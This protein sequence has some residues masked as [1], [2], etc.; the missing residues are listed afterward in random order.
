M[1]E[2]VPEVFNVRDMRNMDH[3]PFPVHVEHVKCLFT[4]DRQEFMQDGQEEFHDL[5]PKASLV[6][7]LLG[8]V[9]VETLVKYLKQWSQSISINRLANIYR[10]D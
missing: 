9:G 6:E 4:I 7:L 3:P 10:G 2:I 8:E 1:P 5:G